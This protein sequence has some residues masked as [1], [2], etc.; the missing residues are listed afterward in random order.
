MKVELYG[1]LRSIAGTKEHHS[2]ATSVQDLLD[3]LTDEYGPKMA[4]YL[5]E[6]DPI[7]SL[8]IVRND[9]VLT[10]T[11]KRRGKVGNDDTIKLL[12]PIGGG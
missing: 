7:E 6:R 9:R 4:K 5:H 3:E 2:R 1:I 8:T 10:K 11:E 12:S